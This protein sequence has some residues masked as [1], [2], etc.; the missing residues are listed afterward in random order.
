MLLCIGESFIHNAQSYEDR[1]SLL[2]EHSTVEKLVPYDF[3][4]PGRLWVYKEGFRLMMTELRRTIDVDII[5]VEFEGE[6]LREYQGNRGN[7]R[8]GDSVR[9]PKM[10]IAELTKKT[11]NLKRED[12]RVKESKEH[13]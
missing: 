11:R 7:F 3:V 12:S 5:G 2:V 1:I 6:T 4:R 10:V 8:V 9:D 13:K